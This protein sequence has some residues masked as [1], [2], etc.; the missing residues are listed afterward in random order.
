M[1]YNDLIIVFLLIIIPLVLLVLCYK[2]YTITYCKNDMKCLNT[3]LINKLEDITKKIKEKRENIEKVVNIELLKKENEE[4]M[5]EGFFGGL[6]NWFS[7]SGPS[8]LQV[9]KNPSNMNIPNLNTLEKK[10]GNNSLE[11]TI[12]SN[13]FPPSE[14]QGNIDDFKDSNNNELLNQ[15]NG[16]TDIK[17]VVNKDHLDKIIKNSTIKK[18]PTI[19]GLSEQKNTDINTNTNNIDIKKMLGTCQFYNDKCPDKYQELGNFSISGVG[20]NTVLACGNVQNVKPAHA[21]A[22]IKN[23]SI[24][25]I[26]VT[27]PGH[28]YNPNKPPKITIEG[29]KGHGSTAEA[30]VD[31]NGYLKLIKVINPGYNYTETPNVMIDAPFLN[32][33]CHLCCQ[34]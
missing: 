6:T 10:I 1:N 17:R 22:Q 2:N 19:E 23:N 12:R 4:P 25:E 26:H 15:I 21:I 24:Y 18:K 8:D 11:N 29:G 20:S 5:I 32:S 13:K 3:Q 33:S 28:G 14:L 16:K 30:V 34:I 7:G 9:P 27:D 31:D